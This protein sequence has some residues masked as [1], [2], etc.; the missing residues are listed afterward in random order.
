MPRTVKILLLGFGLLLLL[1]L[2]GLI[3]GG[4]DGMVKTMG[5]FMPSWL[6]LSTFNL[7]EAVRA[8]KSF[9]REVPYW[10]INF[11]IPTGIAFLILNR[12][13]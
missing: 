11:G 9:I 10:V 12:F 6:I 8:G 3:I 4:H 2:I 5:W 13:A 7:L 1:A